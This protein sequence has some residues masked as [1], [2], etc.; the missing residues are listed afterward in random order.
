MIRGVVILCRYNSSRLPGKI[1]LELK[2]KPILQHIV[3]AVDSLTPDYVVATSTEPTDA[4]IAEYCQKNNIPCFRGSLL[5]VAKRFKDAAEAFSFDYA[6]RINGDNLFVNMEVLKNFLTIENFDD[7]DF[8]TNVPG[9]TF[10]FGMSV[11]MVNMN[12]YNKHFSHFSER[13]QEHVTLYF[14]DNPETGKRLEVKNEKVKNASG[15]NLAIDTPADFKR[16]EYILTES[17]KINSKNFSL[18]ELVALAKGY[19]Q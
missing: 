9:R 1:L 19:E 13:Q 6:T 15:L 7:F 17:Q 11:E 18:S 5:N 12:F 3:E 2:G 14:Y 4:P 8:L 16:A 10:P